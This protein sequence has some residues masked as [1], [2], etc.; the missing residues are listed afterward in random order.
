L[1]ES[2]CAPG[3]RADLFRFSSFL[4]FFLIFIQ[5]SAVF[6][7]AS[8]H[9]P[10][11]A[12]LSEIPT[13]SAPLRQ[14]M[15]RRL[16]QVVGERAAGEGMQEGTSRAPTLLALAAPEICSIHGTSHT[17]TCPRALLGRCGDQDIS[18]RMGGCGIGD[19]PA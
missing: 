16:A 10:Y 7:P 1:P 2:R 15:I 8:S 6:F 12:F 4:A 5:P 13:K 19:V 9:F 3:C 11:P 18:S 17:G 14:R